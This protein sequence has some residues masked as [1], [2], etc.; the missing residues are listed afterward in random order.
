MQCEILYYYYFYYYY[1]YIKIKCPKIIIKKCVKFCVQ[2]CVRHIDRILL[3]LPLYCMCLCM[4]EYVYRFPILLLILFIDDVCGYI[5][6]PHLHMNGGMLDLLYTTVYRNIN[7]QLFCSIHVQALYTMIG[8]IF[9][10]DIFMQIK[11]LLAVGRGC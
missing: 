9:I 3:V 2:F 11:T 8:Y 5:L 10:E 7:L 4:Q 1:I 6:V